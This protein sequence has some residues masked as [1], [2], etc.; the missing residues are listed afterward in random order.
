MNED[1]MVAMSLAGML[2]MNDRSCS[3]ERRVIL[4]RMKGLGHNRTQDRQSRLHLKNGYLAI[5]A[6]D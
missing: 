1:R 3:C 6:E 5:S 2:E 4:K